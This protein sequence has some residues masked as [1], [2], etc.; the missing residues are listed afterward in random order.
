MCII[1]ICLYNSLVKKRA[2]T[3][4]SW[5]QIDVQLKK[6]YDL[7]PNL[8]ET[9]KGYA[10]HEK[11]VLTEVADARAS[12]GRI[13]GNN[14][15]EAIEANNKLSTAIGRLM[16]IVEKYPD[17]KAN[18]NFMML[19]SQLQEIEHKIALARQIYNDCVMDYN[20]KVQ[21]FP[22][23]IVAKIFKFKQAVYFE[24]EEEQKTAP[25]VKF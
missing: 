8:V 14:T 17:L 18:S 3:Q 25:Q 22:S 15:Q 12:V 19:S 16:M 24:I 2:K 1:T 9:V 4:N 10:A 11:E 13:N 5:S 23:N 21:M 6:R 7:I 20:N